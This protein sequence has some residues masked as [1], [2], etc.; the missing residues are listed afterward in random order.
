VIAEKSASEG[1]LCE[2]KALFGMCDSVRLK[3][4]AD[5][6]KRLVWSD[7]SAKVSNSVIINC[8]YNLWVDNKTNYQSKPASQSPK[9]VTIFISRIH[10]DYSLCITQFL[11]GVLLILCTS[12][13]AI[14][15]FAN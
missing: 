10:R 8:S 5:R 1:L 3:T 9:H 14:L 15:K 13:L 6:V 2:L 7:L 11:M 4:S 12:M